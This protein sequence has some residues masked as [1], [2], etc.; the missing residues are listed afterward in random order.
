MEQQSVEIGPFSVR[1]LNDQELIV[2]V[3]SG[4]A[5]SQTLGLADAFSFASDSGMRGLLSKL[6]IA[7]V[8]N[9]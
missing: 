9:N 4:Q 5:F 3:L 8:E 1:T 7:T 2:Y 6:S